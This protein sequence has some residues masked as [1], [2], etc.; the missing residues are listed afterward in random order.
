MR[1]AVRGK[2]CSTPIESLAHRCLGVRRC[3][4]AFPY[5]SVAHSKAAE[6]CRTP[7]ARGGVLAS[8]LVRPNHV[9][10][11]VTFIERLV[12]SFDKSFSPLNQ[13]SGEKSRDCTEDDF[14]KKRGLHRCD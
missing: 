12:R 9:A 4:G 3:S 7:K 2:L 14:L 11:L 1:N 6:H 5:S 13:T 10:M 8:G